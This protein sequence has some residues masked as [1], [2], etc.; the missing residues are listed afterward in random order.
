M[1][2]TTFDETITEK[3]VKA[4]I[5]ALK[6]IRGLDK[7]LD[8]LVDGITPRR[9]AHVAE[10][11]LIRHAGGRGLW[12]HQGTATGLISAAIKWLVSGCIKY[13]SIPRTHFQSKNDPQPVPGT[14]TRFYGNQAR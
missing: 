14:K 6:K 4:A 7:P 9:V 12:R 2:D 5:F 3:D 1:T 8:R 11:A 10:D 13:V